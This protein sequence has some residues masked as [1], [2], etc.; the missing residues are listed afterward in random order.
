[1]VRIAMRGL[2]GLAL[3]VGFC[4]SAS[5]SSLLKLELVTDGSVDPP[6]D[7]IDVKVLL[8]P[9]DE[10]VALE[11]RAFVKLE[12]QDR[13]VPVESA[14]PENRDARGHVV[15]R[16]AMERLDG[17]HEAEARVVIPYA[18]LK[19]P[20]GRH[21]LGYEVRGL[22]GGSADFTRATSLAL[23]VVSDGT[24]TTMR[25]RPQRLVPR[26][27][28]QSRTAYV[29]EGGKAVAREIALEA[30]E[31]RPVSELRT[32]QVAIPGEFQRPAPPLTRSFVP[33]DDTGRIRDSV[34]P[35]QEK[36]WVALSEFE[37]K[38]KRTLLFATNRVDDPHEGQTVDRFGSEPASAITY[39]TCLV[40]IPVQN[41]ARGELEVPSHWWQSRDPT[42][43]FLVEALATL[44]RDLFK[45][46]LSSDDVLLFVHGYNTTF[47]GAVLRTAQLVH[48]LRFPG[49]G[50][51]FSWPSAGALSGYSHDE[52]VNTA[53]VPALLEVLQLLS[54][55]LGTSG[56]S[57][58]IHVIV[59][60][61]GNRLFLQ[62]A[63]EFELTKPPGSG[64][65]FGH[66]ALAAPDVDA[67]TF[68]ALV[69]SVIRQSDSTTLYY[70]Q[71]DRALLAS[72]TIHL[73]K[74]VGLGP[75][76][77]DGLDT[78]NADR[79]NTSFLGHGYF[80]SESP[81]LIDLMLTILHNQKP[82]QR[83]PPL[84]RRSLMLGYAHWW[85]V[86]TA[87]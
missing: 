72:R 38:P 60:S 80:A 25:T 36:P 50:V 43:F 65:V 71:S 19:L 5:A 51:A 7:R 70:C 2:L 39:G 64:K 8:L 81:L 3:V 48:D 69:P 78:I 53:S 11:T 37:S 20:R 33:T 10:D 15:I 31:M 35:L 47:E 28:K 23:V 18:T 84:G 13:V 40:N 14:L 34:V 45:S 59:H 63:R 62:A 83:H 41:H 24:R 32:A 58:K 54:A 4:R 30:E 87:P 55:P 85:L 73:D 27:Q 79:A 68:A 22:R 75:F 61:M 56:R 1:M 46:S 49:K 26:I 44:P 12:G 77:A 6:G 57:R 67:S 42:K 16:T 21:E 82:E 86:G 76:F 17:E 29:I 52:R 9:G 66:V 74:P